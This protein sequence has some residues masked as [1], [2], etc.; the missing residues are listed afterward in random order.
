MIPGPPSFVKAMAMS[1]DSI[2]V[3]WKEPEEPN[4]IILQYTVYIKEL[5]R[6]RDVAP[7]SH[8]VNA[9]QMSHQVD[10]LNANSRYEFWVTAHTTIG[11]GAASPKATLSPTARYGSWLSNDVLIFG[12]KHFRRHFLHNFYIFQKKNCNNL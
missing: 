6:S 8:K 9:L 1:Q 2:L 11:E 10:D 7:R 5:A 12:H 4:G 3:S